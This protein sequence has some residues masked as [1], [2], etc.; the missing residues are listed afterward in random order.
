MR[1]VTASMIAAIG[2]FVGAAPASAFTLWYGGDF[3]RTL[4]DP[5]RLGEKATLILYLE[6]DQPGIQMLSVGVLFDEA[7][8]KYNPKPNSSVGVPS[9][10]LYGMS[11]MMSTWLAAQQSTW[12]LWPGQLPSGRQQVNV[13]WAEVTFAG[14]HATGIGK[15][16][17]LEFEVISAGDG[18]GEINI[19]LSGGGNIFQVNGNPSTP[20]RLEGIPEPT[21]ALLIGLGLAGIAVIAKRRASPI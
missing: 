14:T 9:Y 19:T 20:I 16:A 18:I 2:L 15:I 10:I 5:F 7:F 4:E 11:G 21:T 13:N 17:E 3:Q 6:A 12:L 8:F 1:Q